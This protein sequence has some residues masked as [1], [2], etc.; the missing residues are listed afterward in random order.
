MLLSLSFRQVQRSLVGRPSCVGLILFQLLF[1]IGLTGCGWFGD[2]EGLFVNPR[3]DYLDA[4]AGGKLKVPEGLDREA[5]ADPFPIPETPEQTNANYYP[6]RPPL[7][8]AIYGDDK[9]EEVRM[10]SIGGRRW[11]VVPEDPTTVWP[12]LKQFFTENAV[13]VANEAPAD[14]RI[15]TQWLLV[16]GTAHRDL[17]RRLLEQNNADQPAS[18]DRVLIRVEQGLRE[19]TSEIHLRHLSQ[20]AAPLMAAPVI[21]DL[22]NPF[23]A[24]VA[25]PE[26][27]RLPQ[28]KYQADLQRLTSSDAQVE[29][30][31]LQ[32][33]GA[34][35]AAK[36]SEQLVSMIASNIE[37]LPKSVL[38]RDNSGEPALRLN[39][40]RERAWAS[41]GQA[42]GNAEVEVLESESDA[43]RYLVKLDE[44]T[45]TG[46]EPGFFGR[47]FG[48]GNSGEEYLLQLRKV[49]DSTEEAYWLTVLDTDQ[50]PPDRELAQQLLVLVREYAG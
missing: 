50:Q 8:D 37:T 22:S 2:D 5:V 3:D 12:K 23:A 9:A 6:E 25:E 7:P 15:D 26:P 28:P 4:K 43:Q 48:G 45:F 20:A 30:D 13:Q 24:P 11:L 38:E 47:L 21:P 29:A 40:D 10:Q 1:S 46:E 27:I 36:V 31:M 35:I 42:L 49:P 39:L 19:R 16:D 34:Y 33:I 17:V 41:V 18:I 32:E 44:S 14:G